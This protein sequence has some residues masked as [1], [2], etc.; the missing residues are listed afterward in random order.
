LKRVIKNLPLT[1]RCSAIGTVIGALPGRG[2]YRLLIAYDH[3]KRTVKNPSRPFGQV[4][5]RGLLPLK[6]QQRGDRGAFIPMM[7]LGFRE[8]QD[9]L[10]IGALYIHG[11]RPALC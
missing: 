7:T 4:R 10:L 8:T 11:L 1:L 9:S 3:A 2:R 6:R 5:T